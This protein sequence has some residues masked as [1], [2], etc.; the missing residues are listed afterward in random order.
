VTIGIGTNVDNGSF[1]MCIAKETKETKDRMIILPSPFLE[2][3]IFLVQAP[4]SVACP[5]LPPYP[6]DEAD[7]FTTDRIATDVETSM[8]GFRTSQS[9]SYSRITTDILVNMKRQGVTSSMFL[10]LTMIANYLNASCC[11]IFAYLLRAT[12]ALPC[13]RSKEATS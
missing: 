2:L 11:S 12:S 8:L 6:S 1:L 9:T 4:Y 10:D 5:R 3:R 7:C 13:A